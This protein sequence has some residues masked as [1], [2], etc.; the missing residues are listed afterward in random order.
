MIATRQVG[1][2]NRAAE[3]NI[4]HQSNARFRLEKDNLAQAYELMNLAHRMRP[5]GPLI[6]A[7]LEEYLARLEASS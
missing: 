3:Q 7:K 6:K 5:D 1:A 2:P 4:P